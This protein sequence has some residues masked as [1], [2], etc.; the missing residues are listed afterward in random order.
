MFCVVSAAQLEISLN[1]IMLPLSAPQG[2]LLL[3]L[4]LVL[5]FFLS[6]LLH[7]S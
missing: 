3:L 6:K 5:L 7:V 4:L 1:I 2:C